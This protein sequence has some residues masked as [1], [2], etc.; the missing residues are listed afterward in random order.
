MDLTARA[1]STVHRC[2]S[3]V[4]RSALPRAGPTRLIACIT[5]IAAPSSTHA[6]AS[7]SGDVQNGLVPFLGETCPSS[8]PAVGHVAELPVDDHEQCGAIENCRAMEG[9]QDLVVLSGVA[10]SPRRYPTC[11]VASV[12]HRQQCIASSAGCSAAADRLRGSESY[13]VSGGWSTC[14]AGRPAMISQA[15]RRLA[16]CACSESAGA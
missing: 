15:K 13:S 16:I 8:G 3:I 7:G 11:E 4:I 1:S 14:S 9:G 12:V 6:R 5:L 10:L 2:G